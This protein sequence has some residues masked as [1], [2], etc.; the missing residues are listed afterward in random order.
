MCNLLSL[1]LE[2]NRLVV[3]RFDRIS[4]I[5]GVIVHFSKP[6]KSVSRRKNGFLCRKGSRGWGRRQLAIRQARRAWAVQGID[7]NSLC[8]MIRGRI[9]AAGNTYGPVTRVIIRA[10]TLVQLTVF[11]GQ[12]VLSQLVADQRE[13]VMSGQILRIHGECS[14]ELC[15][16]LLE[17]ALL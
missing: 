6:W 2:G 3:L 16:R 4:L 9:A 15:C 14:F 10:I 13:I 8:G 7:Y 5:R 1:L 12:L 11:F 17:K